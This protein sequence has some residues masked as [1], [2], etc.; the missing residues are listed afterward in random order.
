MARLSLEDKDRPAGYLG[1]GGPMGLAALGLCL[2]LL[3]GYLGWYLAHRGEMRRAY[4][5]KLVFVVAPDTVRV[6]QPARFVVHAV[7]GGDRHPARGRVVDFVASPLDKVQILSATGFSGAGYAKQENQ[8]KGGTDASGNVTV[9]VK[10]AAPGP[11]T[12]VAADS[13]AVESAAVDFNAR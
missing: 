1:A 10:P 4:G 12:L 11:F 13:V 5:V 8:A 2:A 7:Q 3:A 9:L 6:G